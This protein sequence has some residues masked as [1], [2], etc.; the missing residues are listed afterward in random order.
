MRKAREECD[1][2]RELKVARQILR[3]QRAYADRIKREA[4]A[5]L[6]NDVANRKKKANK[7]AASAIADR[8][9]VKKKNKESRGRAAPKVSPDKSNKQ[10][11]GKSSSTKG[12][13]DHHH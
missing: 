11:G 4:E 3:E 13:G 2:R 6:R 7:S 10:Q 9:D 1:R 12:G 8:A 5:K